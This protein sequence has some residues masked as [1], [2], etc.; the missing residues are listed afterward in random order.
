MAVE[1]MKRKLDEHEKSNAVLA[2]SIL[3]LI[4][5]VA[6]IGYYFMDVISKWQGFT[7]LA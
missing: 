5:S 7:F 6:A 2:I 1:Y 3:T 4:G